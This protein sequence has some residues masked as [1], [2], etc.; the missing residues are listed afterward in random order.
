[1]RQA[2]SVVLTLL[3]ISSLAMAAPPLRHS[4]A[5]VNQRLADMVACDEAYLYNEVLGGRAIHQNSMS[6]PEP[7]EAW[8]GNFHTQQQSYYA[9]VK[10][11]LY[12]LGGKQD[13][14]LLDQARDLL[15]WVVRHGYDP[16]DPHFY[17]KYSTKTGTWEKG[18]YPEFNMINVAGL[19]CYTH[20]RRHGSWPQ[21]AEG[22]LAR[23]TATSAFRA[24]Q[25]QNLYGSGYLALKLLDCYDCRRE[26]RFLTLAKTVVAHADAALWDGEYGGWFIDGKA[27]GPL[28]KYTTKFTHINSNMIQAC[29]RLDLLGEHQYRAHALAALQFLADRSR[30]PDGGWVRHNVRDGSDPKQPPGIGDGG[31]TEP[32]TPVVYDRNM[33]MIVACC[34]A[35]QVTG[36]AKYLQW[37]D[38]TLDRMEKTHLTKYPVG[39]NYGYTGANDY[40]NTWCHLW[41]LKAFIAMARLWG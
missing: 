3:A 31:T 17:L 6:K 27:G 18:F 23:I 7:T 15:D 8:E 40:E 20:Y 34:L 2:L 39:V 35:W 28:P 14:A 12:E 30:T 21:I 11:D 13:A 10:M 5:W 25:T 41:G 32:G 16:A 33:Q 37:V 22:V 26:E 38:N 19:L 29:L 24:D 9:L 4:R 36:E 1:M